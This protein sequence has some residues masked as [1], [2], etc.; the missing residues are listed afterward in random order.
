ML[1]VKLMCPFQAKAG[2]V[3]KAGGA[4]KAG[5][6][7]TANGPSGVVDEAEVTRLTDKV[8]EQVRIVYSCMCL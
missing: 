6:D 8:T 4:A 7:V 1:F 5:G 3:A 2:G